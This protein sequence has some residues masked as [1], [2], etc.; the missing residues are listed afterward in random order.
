MLWNI[1]IVHLL[2]LMSPGPDFFYVSKTAAGNSSRNAFCAVIGI[3]MGVAFWATSALLGLAILFA[4]S[5]LWHGIV[6]LLGGSYLAYIGYKMLN[7]RNNVVFENDKKAQQLQTTSI[8]QEILKGLLVNLS[9]A[10]V[11][12]YFSSVLSIYLANV[13]G[14]EHIILV[15][16][17]I[18][19]ETFLYFSI[20]AL[21]FSRPAAKRFYSKYSRWLDNGAGVVFIAFGLY[22]AYA[23][24][25]YLFQ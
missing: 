23:G 14:I 10:K 6:V 5:P 18:L 24:I 2:G 3:T 12:I 8:K 9:N 17:V 21:L 13:N 20:I 4:T 16:A 1:M 22:L 15:L 19:I 7:V 11:V 25:G